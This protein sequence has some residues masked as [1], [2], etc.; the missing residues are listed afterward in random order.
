MRLARHPDLLLWWSGE[1]LTVRN[2]ESGATLSGN[3]RLYP[4]L[5]AFDRPRSRSEALGRFPPQERRLAGEL[6][7]FLV[8]QRF[9]LPEAEA[10]RKDS[11]RRAWG[12]NVASAIHHAASRDLR[13]APPGAPQNRLIRE[14]MA[15]VPPVPLF[16]RYRSVPRRTL[17]DGPASEMTLAAA[18]DA[19]RTIRRFRRRPVPFADL[20]AVVRGTWGLTGI[21]VGG[22][23]GNL[24]AKTSPSAGSLHPVE[25]YVLAWN[26]R[27]LAPGL[28]HYD[29]RT[30]ELRRLRRGRPRVEAVRAASG[31]TWVGGAA[32]LCVMTAVIAR[33][34]R[35]YDDET[36]YRTLWL[37]AGHLAQTFCL[38]ATARGLGPFT[39]AAIQDSYIE[40]L[41][42]LD[43]I[44]EF[45]LYLCG[46]GVPTGRRSGSGS[47]R[48]R[49]AAPGVR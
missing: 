44:R 33:S 31:Q 27:G 35:K 11:R 41:L 5:A 15:A 38:L 40:R 21:H 46:A 48:T 28:Y 24:I 29:V 39:T 17:L 25:S 43:G 47:R 36:T 2:L 26:V 10:R 9:L 49:R 20:S 1:G 37:D 34:L 42:G 14:R 13:Y 12:D 30:N 19:R 3:Q 45:P 7:D 16:K 23:F 32:F 8:R 6:L 4:V 22:I 18:L